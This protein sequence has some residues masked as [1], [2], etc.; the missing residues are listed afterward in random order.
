MSL[1]KMPEGAEEYKAR[2]VAGLLFIFFLPLGLGV[3]SFSNQTLAQIE[4]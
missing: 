1:P 4:L 3:L 2:S